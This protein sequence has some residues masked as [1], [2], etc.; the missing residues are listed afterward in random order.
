MSSIQQIVGKAFLV[1]YVLQ[2]GSFSANYMSA[3]LIMRK[4]ILSTT[5]MLVLANK[6]GY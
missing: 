1:L 2:V 5:S 6:I 3:L 4:G